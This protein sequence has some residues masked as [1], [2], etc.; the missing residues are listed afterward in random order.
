MGRMASRAQNPIQGDFG[1]HWLHAVA[2]GRGYLHG[3]SHTVDSIKADV[4]ITHPGE[5]NGI[6]NPSVWVQVKTSHSAALRRNGDLAFSLDATT[7]DVL[8]R[9]NNGTRRI[10]LVIRLIKN[11]QDVI[12]Q[13]DG[14]LLHGLARWVSLE[15]K[16]AL[17][18]SSTTVLLPAKNRLDQ[19]GLARM[20]S[21]YGCP[22]STQVPSVEEW[23]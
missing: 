17:S 7:Y 21:N 15:G 2:A 20:I 11:G 5:V 16:P 6:W 19:A 23:G 22:R 9:T 14:T 12:E 10:L 3:T 1:E 13:P 18:G 8:R 4:T